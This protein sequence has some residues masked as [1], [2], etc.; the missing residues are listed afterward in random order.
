MRVA[1]RALLA[2]CGGGIVAIAWRTVGTIVTRVVADAHARHDPLDGLVRIGIDEVAY[3]KGH[4]YLIVVV[5][6]DSGRLVWGAAGVT[7]K[8]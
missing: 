5:D 4:R 3:K 7:R 1:G 2:I 6:H 8:P